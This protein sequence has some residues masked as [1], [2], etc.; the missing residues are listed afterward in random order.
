MFFLSDKGRTTTEGMDISRRRKSSKAPQD[1]V[2]KGL[3]QKG[4]YRVDVQDHEIGLFHRRNS[5]FSFWSGAKYIFVLSVLLWW[6]PGV[7]Q[8]IAGYV[9]GRRTGAP[10]KAVLAAILP[11]V[12]IFVV[13]YA[14]DHGYIGLN[15]EMVASLPSTIA[16]HVSGAIPALGPYVGYI[17]SYLAAFIVAMKTTFA[18]GTNGYLVTIV[19]AY[20]GGVMAEQAMRESS[21]HGRSGTN[22]S[23]SQP[24]IHRQEASEPMKLRSRNPVSFSSMKKVP[25]SHIAMAKAAPAPRPVKEPEVAEKAVRAQVDREDTKRGHG[26]M[27]RSQREEI[28]MQH[29][30]EQA[31]RRYEHPKHD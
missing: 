1:E 21:A 10:W 9:G 19:F 25:T 17:V 28:R 6:L 24:I 11:L 23:I 5:P 26:K 31:L 7:G 16:Q 13:G 29:F 3:I 30:V 14:V 22:V 8:M 2:T 15:P 18:M 12:I 27:S 4:V 20:I